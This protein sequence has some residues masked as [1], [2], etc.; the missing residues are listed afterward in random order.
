MSDLMLSSAVR[1]QVARV[2]LVQT[3][4]GYANHV[5]ERAHR[6]QTGQDMVEYAGVL[7]VVAA[8]VLAVA[9]QGS[10]IAGFITSGISKE[11][12][13]IFNGK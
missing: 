11:V 9:T 8:I 7:I 6:E 13:S 12:N 3:L 5:V 2:N 1:A 10:Q 4:V